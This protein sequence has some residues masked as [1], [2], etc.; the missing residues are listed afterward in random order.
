MKPNNSPAGSKDALRHPT[1]WP[2]SS[3]IAKPY[4]R[5]PRSR[6]ALW[7]AGLPLLLASLS[8]PA[9]DLLEV[10][11]QAQA[12][13]PI[14]RGAVY[15]LQA[16]RERVPQARA[17]LL[18]AV[19]LVG[20]ASRQAGQASFNELAPVPRDVHNRSWNL[21]L[22]QPLWRATASAALDQ[23]G[24]QELLAEAQF[25]LAEQD[26]I[27]RT[28]QAYLDVLVAQ[29]AEHVAHLQ[30]SAM[31]QQRSLARRTFEGGTGTVTD[32]HEAQSRLDLSRAQAVV[33]GNELQNKLAELTRILGIS[34]ARLAGLRADSPLPRIQ[35]EAA[36]PWLDS[37]REQS[38]QV[39]IARA[40]LE[41][42]D[43]EIAKSQAAHLPTLDMTAT[44]GSNF[45][46]GS[47]TSPADISVRSRSS[48]VGVS[49]TIPLYA[50]GG[51]Q[52]RVREALALKGKA[53]EDLE[54]A[55]RQAAT[56]ARQAFAG[57]VNGA[58]QVQALGS[59]IVSS[60]SSLDANKVGYLVGTR[61]NM[62]VL[63]AEQQLYTAQRDWHKARAETLVQG[64][65]LKAA[66]ATLGEAD[67]SV[68]ND[69]LETG[70]P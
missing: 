17:A 60:K 29:E 55:R 38:I 59:A 41:V 70:Q 11:R 3:S 68:I 35:P 67:L 43:R 45:T 61:I 8:A 15:A 14:Y 51:V 13:D 63:N 65:R 57:V 23:A 20:A 62:E 26:L 44:Y 22:T 54:A 4:S 6:G 69:M 5:H 31:E 1:P 9:G 36:Q 21:Q 28:A 47:I 7:L 25:R 2:K 34:H 58:A 30:I 37:A 46:S 16:A 52:A 48:Q 33:A 39:R 49:L 24:Q 18:P 42:A 12:R 32:V 10:Y 27:L 56:Q 19:S 40:T 64:L 53:E 66:N 50:G